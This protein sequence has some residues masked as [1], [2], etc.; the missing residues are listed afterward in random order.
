MA[1]RTSTRGTGFKGYVNYAI[2]FGATMKLLTGGWE[3]N[4]AFA[5]N[6]G[7]P[8]TV[9]NG[10]D[11]SGTDEFTQRVNQCRNPFAGSEPWIQTS[12]TAAN[13][14]SGSTRMRYVEPAANTWGTEAR[15]SIYGP[16]YEDIDLS[17]LKNTKFQIN[18]FPVNVQFRAEMFNLFNQRQSCQP[19]LHPALQRLLRWRKLRQDRFH[20]RFGQ[21][22][23]GH[24]A[25]RTVQR[26][27]G[28]ED[29]FLGKAA[30]KSIR[31]HSA[32]RFG[33]IRHS[34]GRCRCD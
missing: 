17:V 8:I 3:L 13:L 15:N 16:G 5:F 28:H 31:H 4:T 24:R 2:P 33:A 1:T 25:G 22:F 19:G 10:D 12:A 6:G 29:S 11:T 21:L 26:A 27:A 20:D 7:Q 18:D 9:Y 14:S 34:A 23:S 32:G 30:C